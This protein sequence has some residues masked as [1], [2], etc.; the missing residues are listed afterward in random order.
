[1]NLPISLISILNNL[2]QNNT[3]PFIVGGS[4][5]DHFLGLDS[6][7]YDI[8][9]YGCSLDKLQKLLASFGNVKS[10][11]K[12]FGVLK[13]SIDAYEFDFALP[14]LE[15]KIAF[16]HKGFSVQTD[17]FLSTQEAS[18]RRDFTI[19]AILFDYK[20]KQFIDHYNGIND[21]H[22]R[23]LRYVNEASFIEDPLRVYRAVQ[24]CARFGLELEQK[25]FDLCKTLVPNLQELPK[26][27][28]WSEFQKLLLKSDNPSIGFNLMLR[29]GIIEHY[30]EELYGIVGVKQNPYYH[31]EGDVWTHTMMVIDEEAKIIQTLDD[32]FKKIYLM[33]SALCHDLGKA[34][35][36]KKI[37]Q[38]GEEKIVAYGHEDASID[39]AI[40]F[41]TKLTDE[42]E[43]LNYVVPLVK[44]HYAPSAFFKQKAKSASIR[45][46]ALKLGKVTIADLVLLAQADY[47]GRTPSFE[48]NPIYEAKEWILNKAQNLNVKHKA[49]KNLVSGKDLIALGLQPGPKFKEVLD[50]SYN[51][52]LEGLVNSKEEAIAKIIESKELLNIDL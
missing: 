22:N 49:L 46:L 34:F 18:K 11:G 20:N 8:E 4:V 52:Q 3:L 45:R 28:I 44:Y 42:K 17:Q 6:K 13:L 5:R 2:L 25:S 47:F 39:L 24:F 26:E 32:K 36:T 37:I 33:I 16:G 23:T 41:I 27:R 1:V 19:N 50:F 12:S 38:N 14:R 40:R 29:L 7:D 31:N 35:T 10:V 48:Q 51:L 9:V 43:L 30:F 21:L 15:T